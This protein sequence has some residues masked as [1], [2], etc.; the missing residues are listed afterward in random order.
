MKACLRML[1]DRA[2]SDLGF[3]G[4]DLKVF[5]RNRKLGLMGRNANNGFEVT[6]CVI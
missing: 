3:V 2:N 5:F 6:T 1:P 4:R